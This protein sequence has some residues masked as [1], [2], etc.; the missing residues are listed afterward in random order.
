M[1]T[2]K[3]EQ[4]FGDKIRSETV[5]TV[6]KLS[7]LIYSLQ[8]TGKFQSDSTLGAIQSLKAIYA[9]SAP[10]AVYNRRISSDIR[11]EFTQSGRESPLPIQL[12]ALI[13]KL[14][15]AGSLYWLANHWLTIGNG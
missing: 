2:G 3:L 14:L 13:R 9:K 8:I 15:F 11:G 6:H 1:Q 7:P 10:Q 5:H 4:K 12:A